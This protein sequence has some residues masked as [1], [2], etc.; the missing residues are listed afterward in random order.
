MPCHQ[1]AV[2]NL[3]AL[4]PARQGVDP[5]GCHCGPVLATHLVC[6]KLDEPYQWPSTPGFHSLGAPPP[7]GARERTHRHT[8]TQAHTH[9]MGFLDASEP[10]HAVC[11]L[12][13]AFPTWCR[14]VE[15]PCS[16]RYIQHI[17]GP[18]LLR[19]LG[20]RDSFGRH[21]EL[22]LW[23]AGQ[24]F[25]YEVVTRDRLVVPIIVIIITFSPQLLL[26]FRSFARWMSTLPT[27]DMYAFP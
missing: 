6:F 17:D 8:S 20:E 16:E 27:V 14:I 10:G 15:M 4:R 3:L 9:L 13:G 19:Q 11:S 21:P 7:P 18:G 25:L 23:T 2:S 22:P 26:V 12:E 1:P 5:C 24:P